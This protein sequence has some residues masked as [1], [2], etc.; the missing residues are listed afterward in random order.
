MTES[1]HGKNSFVMWQDIN[2]EEG[3]AEPAILIESFTDSIRITQ[4]GQAIN[5][6]YESINELSRILKK[7][8]QL[9][10]K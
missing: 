6:N 3:I 5:L 1:V 7:C 10:K 8:N 9:P 2:P 4:Y